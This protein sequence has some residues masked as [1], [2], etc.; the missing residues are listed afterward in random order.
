MNKPGRY[1]YV[2]AVSVANAE[3]SPIGLSSYSGTVEWGPGETR[4]DQ[5][6]KALRS[7]QHD[8]ESKGRLCNFITTFWSLEPDE[9][10]TDD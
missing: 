10:G 3:N 1:F 5:Y 9:P 8:L 7:V 2:I 6:R 4:S